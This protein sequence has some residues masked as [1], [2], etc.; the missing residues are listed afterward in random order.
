M[1]TTLLIAS[2]LIFM[3]GQGRHQE[4]AKGICDSGNYD[5]AVLEGIGLEILRQGVQSNDPEE[6]ILALFGASVALNEKAEVFFE[7]AYQSPHPQIQLASLSMIARS[8]SE[9]SL[10]ILHQAIGH[11]HPL[12]R[13]EAAFLLAER[14]AP[15]ASLR[16]ESLMHKIPSEAHFLFPRLFAMVGDDN[17]KRN[18]RRLLNHS[19]E[20]VRTETI[21]AIADSH[22]DDL[23]KEIRRILTHPDAISKEAAAAAIGLLKDEKALPEL[24]KLTHN[25]SD[26]VKIAALESLAILKDKN[27]P[28]RLEHLALKGNLF[29]IAALSQ[30]PG[31]EETLAVLL[32]SPDRSV[33][34]NATLSLLQLK[35]KRATQGLLELLIK[36]ARDYGFVPLHSPA[37][38]LVAYRVVPSATQNLDKEGSGFELSLRLRERALRQVLELDEASFFSVARTLLNRQQ[39]DLVPLL[40]ELIENKGNES[41]KEFLKQEEQRAGAPFIRAW[42]ALALYRMKVDEGPYEQKLRDWLKQEASL[43]LV[44]FRPFVPWEKREGTSFELTPNEKAALYISL[45][46]A[47]ISRDP[48]KATPLLLEMISSGA[49]KNRFVLAGLLLRTI[50]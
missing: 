14:K 5:E 31:S 8:K 20:K 29:A 7:S 32:N 41:A 6:A 47:L 2:N 15:Q 33:R 23:I 18:L 21:L 19:D 13:L 22:R 30:C 17:A 9:S 36:D 43:D 50:Q 37:G 25:P 35:D 48:N 24:E 4:A 3:A 45:L 27:A 38:A 11:P 40:M 26:F 16:L 12:I 49:G 44:R 1:L 46:E 39:N 42:A 10:I 28:K 34:A